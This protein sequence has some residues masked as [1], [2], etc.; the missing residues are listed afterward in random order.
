MSLTHD[1]AVERVRELSRQA[2]QSRNLDIIFGSNGMSGRSATGNYT[3]IAAATGLSRVHV[4]KVLKGKT[5]PSYTVLLRLSEVT[6]I[7][8]EQ[9]SRYIQ[10]QKQQRQEAA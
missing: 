9:I 2:T 4:G 3:L 6:G 1:Q 10:D 5:V 8:I 7:G